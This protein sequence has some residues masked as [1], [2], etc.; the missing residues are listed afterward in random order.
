MHDLSARE[1]F[2]DEHFQSLLLKISKI[3]A[4]MYFVY[5]TMGKKCS[6]LIFFFNSDNDWKF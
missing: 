6:E 3:V 2:P 5:Q 1:K 4:E